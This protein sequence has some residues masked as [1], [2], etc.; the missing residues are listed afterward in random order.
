MLVEVGLVVVLDVVEVVVVEV[1]VVEEVV[2]EV[3]VEVLVVVVVVEIF[4][5]KQ[6]SFE[7]SFIDEN[8]NLDTFKS[9]VVP[10]EFVV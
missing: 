5:G 2:V 8:A 9:A 10:Q 7:T 3:K 1:V 6:K 4:L